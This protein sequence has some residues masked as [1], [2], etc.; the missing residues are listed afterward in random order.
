MQIQQRVP[1]Q[2]A[3]VRT[4][5]A[6]PPDTDETLKTFVLQWFEQMRT[7][8]IDRSLLSSEY[9]AHLTDEA[10]QGMSQHLT[11]YE[12]GASPIGVNVLRRHAT[13]NQTF[14]LTKILFPRGDAA[15]LL[16]GFN[17]SGRIT[18]VSLMSMAGD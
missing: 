3:V 17:Q 2:A 6:A 8:Q 4:R 18:G 14:Y 15:S 1:A 7:G 13:P 10:V 9:D 12:F 11:A 16:F 5:L